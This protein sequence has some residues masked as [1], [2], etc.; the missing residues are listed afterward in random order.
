MACLGIGRSPTE[1]LTGQI[2]PVGRPVAEY[3]IGI[4]V[5]IRGTDRERQSLILTG[6]LVPDRGQDRRMI[7][8]GGCGG[9]KLH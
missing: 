1:R 5:G 7:R 8:T 9:P 3:V 4:A 6:R 2:R